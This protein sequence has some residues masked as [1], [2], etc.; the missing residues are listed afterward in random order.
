MLM[1]R[2]ECKKSIYNDTM[3]SNS[4][5]FLKMY[6]HIFNGNNNTQ[7][8]MLNPQAET[9]LTVSDLAIFPISFFSIFY[10]WKPL[11]NLMIHHILP[12]A[13]VCFT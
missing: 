12:R 2:G 10:G 11:Y 1:I 5:T 8:T 7:L 3:R 9:L 6:I 4:E 13:S